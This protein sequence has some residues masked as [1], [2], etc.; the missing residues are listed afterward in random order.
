MSVDVLNEP[1]TR[2][3]LPE[4]LRQSPLEHLGAN[5]SRPGPLNGRD[6]VFQLAQ[7]FLPDA[8]TAIVDV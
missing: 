6:D 5:W 2:G 7:V 1:S 4:G 3:L 8:A